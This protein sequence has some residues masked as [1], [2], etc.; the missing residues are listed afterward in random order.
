[1]IARGRNVALGNVCPAAPL[2]P[3]DI[4]VNDRRN[5][6]AVML[7]EMLALEPFGLT[8]GQRAVLAELVA[9]LTEGS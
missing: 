8:D 1:M 3:A 5:A 7:R 6:Q 2:L 9:E 4:T